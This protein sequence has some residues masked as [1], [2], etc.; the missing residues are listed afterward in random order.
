M[1]TLIT[2]SIPVGG[3]AG[4]FNLYSNTDGYT[5]PFATGISAA[6]L[7]AGYTSTV[8]PEGTTVI[9][10]V[11]TGWCTNYIDITINLIPTTTTTS[12]TSTSSTTTTSTTAVPT[13]TTT[14]SS[15]STTTSTTTVPVTTTTTTTEFIPILNSGS[16]G[17]Q[18]NPAIEGCNPLDFPYTPALFPFPPSLIALRVTNL[19]VTWSDI[20]YV[21][22][23]SVISDPNMTITYDGNVIAPAMQFVPITDSAWQY[24]LSMTVD[25]FSCTNTLEVW[26]IRVKLTGYPIS[27]IAIANI[28]FET[29]PFCP[30]CTTTT[31]TTII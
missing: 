19:S 5:V 7:T 24:P 16:S 1:T 23:V 17:V 25:T 3:D 11:S 22:I 18:A 6:A 26:E 29:N 12:S 13:T 27:N 31:T 28:R 10:V 21:E 8:V 2:L 30:D 9:R 14:S 20:E 15:T 4:P